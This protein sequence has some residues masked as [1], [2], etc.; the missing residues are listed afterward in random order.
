MPEGT[1]L[2]R[3]EY[4]TIPETERGRLG[5]LGAKGWELVAA[6]AGSGEP[7]LYLKRPAPGFRE[8]V[9]LDQRRQVFQSRGLDATRNGE[10]MP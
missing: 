1:D 8:R 10:R 9:T 5:E 3:W 6:G 7:V 2:R 4:L